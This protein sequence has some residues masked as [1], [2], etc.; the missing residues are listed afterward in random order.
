[1]PRISKRG[2][3]CKSRFTKNDALKMEISRSNETL[4]AKQARLKKQKEYQLAYYE[5]QSDE[6]RATRL[7]HQLECQQ[8]Y[9]DNQSSDERANRLVQQLKCQQSYRD[10]QNAD[11]RATRLE[12]QLEYQKTHYISESSEELINRRKR[13]LDDQKAHFQ[14]QSNERRIACLRNQRNYQSLRTKGNSNDGYLNIARSVPESGFNDSLINEINLVQWNL[15]VYFVARSFGRAKSF[16][17]A[18]R[19][20]TSS[21]SVVDRG[22]WFYPL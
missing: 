20:A 17:V 5:K 16:P 1:M 8:S 2:S 6:D 7:G 14:E 11:K 13:R 22:R 3:Q 21:P 9:R 19:I 15:F 4:G 10:N 12:R 18:L